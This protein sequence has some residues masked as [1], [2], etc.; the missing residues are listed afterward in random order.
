MDV[1]DWQ[2]FE[3]VVQNIR[4][5]VRELATTISCSRIGASQPRRKHADIKIYNVPARRALHAIIL[6]R[7]AII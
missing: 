3:V 4:Q 6:E 7:Y 1:R 5:L 2:S